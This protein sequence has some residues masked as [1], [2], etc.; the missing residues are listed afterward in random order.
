M[1]IK[2]FEVRDIGT[3]MPVMVTKIAARNSKEHWLLRRVGLGT[4]GSY[5]FLYTVLNHGESGWDCYEWGDRTRHISHKF[6]EENWDDLD[7]GQ[8]ID[9]EY[10]LGETLEPQMPEAR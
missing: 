2:L 9:V 1:D 8:V 3:L 4:D 7:N 5:E 10:I 6:I